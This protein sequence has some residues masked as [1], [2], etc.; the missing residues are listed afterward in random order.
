MQGA[1]GLLE[2]IEQQEAVG[3]FLERPGFPQEG[4]GLDEAGDALLDVPHVH[5]A[6]PQNE[7]GFAP[8]RRSRRYLEQEA[9]AAVDIAFLDAPEALR[10]ELVVGLARH[11]GPP[12]FPVPATRSRRP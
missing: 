7:H 12:G 2:T 9:L 1:L 8:Q 5:E 6:A 3:E 10:K 4:R 11:G